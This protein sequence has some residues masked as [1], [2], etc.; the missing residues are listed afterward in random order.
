[1]RI[2]KIAMVL[3]ILVDIMGQGLAFP[4]FSVL[5]LS[6]ASTMLAAD[7]PTSTRQ[8]LY[9]VLV[10]VF[11]LSWFFGAVYVSRIS[12]SIGRK[13][14]MLICLSGTLAGYVM[15]VA[16]IMLDSFWLLLASRAVTGFTA[17]NQP[18]A[19]AALVDIS[20]DEADKARNMGLV[21]LGAG[22]GLVAGPII[23]GVF[24]ASAFGAWALMLPFVIGGVLIA[25]TIGIVIVFF[26]ETSNTRVPLSIHPAA[27]F[28]LLWQITQRPVILR[29]SIVFLAYMLSFIAFYVFFNTALERWF[30]YGTTGQ[31]AAMFGLG[32]T[33]AVT[34]T[35]LAAKIAALGSPR[36]LMV[37]FICFEVLVVLAFV[38]LQTPVVAFI[39]VALMGFIHA[40]MYPAFLG[41]FS[42]ATS[43]QDQGWVM[44]V[45]VALFTL[46]SAVASFLGAAIGAADFDALFVFT[47]ATAVL[48]LALIAV[49]WRSGATYTLTSGA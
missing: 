45:A 41:L 37:S 40:Y 17:G 1:M 12:D 38:G 8:L 19:Q 20:T 39:C 29:L 18:I 22:I 2:A 14:G 13:R 32:I 48:T 21:M 47:A 24:S 36:R 35:V 49:F 30:G 46:A 42:K 23:G 43:A 25:L 4:I 11:F 15:A 10:G 3:V 34:S 33:M 26:E 16:A 28:S 31:A 44:G 5:M 6:D 27:V 7:T 9:G